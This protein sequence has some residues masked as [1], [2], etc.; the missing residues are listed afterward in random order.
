[1]LKLQFLEI[2]PDNAETEGLF[3]IKNPKYPGFKLKIYWLKQR[4]KEGLKLIL[5]KNGDETVGFIEYVPIEKAWRP[6]HGINYMFIHCMW[7]YPKK[8]YNLGYG[9]KLIQHCLEEAKKQNMNGVATFVSIGSWMAG[10]ELFLKNEFEITTS[11]DRFQLAI[12]Q[13][14]DKSVPEFY[15][16]EKELGKYKGLNLVY[17][18]QCPLFIK[19]V[20]EMRATAKEFGLEL[21]VS[22]LD[23]AQKAQNAPSGY[24]VYS[25]VNDGKLLADHYISNTR[26]R[27]ILSK[28]LK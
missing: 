5:L 8:N 11:K 26:F 6:V 15:D 19:S 4:I 17:A 28:E 12:K 21:K 25:L 18:N 1:M 22:I 7:I 13:F 24:G 10:K 3:C 20:E 9:S 27:N 2:T 14:N 23:T 16:W